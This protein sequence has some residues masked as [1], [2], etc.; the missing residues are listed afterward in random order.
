[1]L[2]HK[3]I[4]QTSSIGRRNFIQN[5]LHGTLIPLESLDI[6]LKVLN[7]DMLLFGFHVLPAFGTLLPFESEQCQLW[8]II[9]IGILRGLWD[10]YAPLLA[11]SRYL[12]L[13]HRALSLLT[14]VLILWRHLSWVNLLLSRKLM[15][16]IESE[17]ML[18]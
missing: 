1:M 3:L 7:V 10:L 8:V 6:I 18:I 2:F 5:A 16:H 13:C 11:H 12:L 15:S 14:N 4:D 17:L 9:C